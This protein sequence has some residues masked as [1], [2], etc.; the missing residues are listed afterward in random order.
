[1]EGE[2]EIYLLREREREWIEWDKEYLDHVCL[3]NPTVNL[4]GTQVRDLIDPSL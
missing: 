2:R 3:F 1:M 4:S